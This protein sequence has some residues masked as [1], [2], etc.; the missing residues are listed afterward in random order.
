MV[1][2]ASPSPATSSSPSRSRLLV[3]VTVIVFG[4]VQARRS[5]SSSCS[6]RRA[7]RSGCCRFIVAIEVISF[8]SRPISLSVRLFANMLAG[9]ITLK[10]FAR[11]R[12]GARRARASSASSAR[13]PA[14]HGGRRSPRS[15]SWSPCC[16]PMCSPCSP[17]STS[18]TPLHLRP[19]SRNRPDPPITR[20]DPSGDDYHGS[21]SSQVH[22]RR[23]RLLSAWS[24]PPSASATSSATSCRARCAIRSAA[25][26]SSPTCSSASRSREATGLFGLV[27]ALVILFT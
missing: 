2:G 19:L 10:V 24:A 15:S 21:S 6:C 23:P 11:L 8:L 13:P 4:F 25:A 18:T 14:R 9:H 1:P 16:R 26:A 5:T 27:V 20:T 3:I 12:R 22:R 17:A 7:C